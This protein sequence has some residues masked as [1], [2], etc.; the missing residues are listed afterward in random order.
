[1]DRGPEYQGSLFSLGW[2]PTMGQEGWGKN[3]GHP[4]PTPG[5]P[6]E[7]L[8]TSLLEQGMSWGWGP[9]KVDNTGS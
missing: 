7:G 4:L 6:H 9:P 8:G 3:E 5:N 1:M 2:I